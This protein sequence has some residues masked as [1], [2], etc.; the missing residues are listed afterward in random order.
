VG[1]SA[2]TASALMEAAERFLARY[3]AS[4]DPD[5][6]ATLARSR[7]ELAEADSRLTTATAEAADEIERL[8][9]DEDEARRTV[10]R[11][12]TEL[13][14]RVHGDADP[15]RRAAS[16]AALR[17]R[18]TTLEAQL[19]R[20]R[21]DAEAAV[22]DS[23]AAVEAALEHRDRTRQNLLTLARHATRLAEE[24]AAERRPAFDPL[25]NVGA[26]GGALRAEADILAPDID[27]AHGHVELAADAL[28]VAVATLEGARALPP[29][30]APTH[31]DV[32]TALA[33]L[34]DGGVNAAPAV[35]VEP[36]AAEDPVLTARL[37]DTVLRAS[38]ERPVVLLTSD[39]MTIA[40]AIEL[41]VEDGAVVPVRALITDDRSLTPAES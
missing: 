20:A 35:V 39:Q 8:A 9:E 1:E 31:D 15:A 26:L 27:A 28:D 21:D 2:A 3:D 13:Q 29:A 11:L 5:R 36:L 38:T 40:W 30:G 6:A 14:T 19:A 37:H 32:A 10:S 17:D 41:P 4:A 24:I 25:A 18:I 12:E 23:S 33:D 34:L 22:A 7:A 16:A